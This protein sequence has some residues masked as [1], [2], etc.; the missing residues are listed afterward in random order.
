MYTERLA[1]AEAVVTSFVR[2]DQF[3]IRQIKKYGVLA[4]IA[5]FNARQIFLLYGSIRFDVTSVQT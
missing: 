1:R 5:K 2:I 4:E 3:K